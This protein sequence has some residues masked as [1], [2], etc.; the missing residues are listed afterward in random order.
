MAYFDSTQ[1]ARRRT[2]GAA[3]TL[4]IQGLIGYVVLIGLA[5]HFE[6]PPVHRPLTGTSFPVPTPT[7]MPTPTPAARETTLP[8]IP[9]PSPN[10]PLP[11]KTDD[12]PVDRSLP[13][14]TGQI[15]FPPLP[16]PPPIP[17]V[18]FDAK[19]PSPIG[20]PAAWALTDDYPALDL[21]LGHEGI[22]GFTVT[23]GADG[24]VGACT[25]T[26]SSGFRGLDAAA[27]S[28]VKK[29]ARFAPATDESGRKVGG[30]YGNSVRWRIPR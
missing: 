7:P 26:H 16:P 8:R 1:D 29:R 5:G 24:R 4:V 18:S 17:S 27:C 30:T 20:S 10:P 13:T 6:R 2:I 14:G 22:T 25:V 11:P 28:A 9:A 19:G 21:D 23:V 15:D 12:T 3:G